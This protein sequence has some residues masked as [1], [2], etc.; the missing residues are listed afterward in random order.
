MF[1]ALAK[2]S[3]NVVDVYQRAAEFGDLHLGDL[4]LIRINGAFPYLFLYIVL[5]TIL[6]A[7]P[8]HAEVRYTP[9]YVPVSLDIYPNLLE[10]LKLEVFKKNRPV[11]LFALCKPIRLAFNK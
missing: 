6:T 9:T 11:L 10:E 2:L 7:V 3:A 5:S 4:H 8:I 1:D